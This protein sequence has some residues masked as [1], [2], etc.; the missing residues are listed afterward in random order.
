MAASP[1]KSNSTEIFCP[2]TCRTTSARPLSILCN[3]YGFWLLC[4]NTQTHARTHECTKH[5]YVLHIPQYTTFKDNHYV[6]AEVRIWSLL[7][8]KEGERDF[9]FFRCYWQR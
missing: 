2:R 7:R 9:P 4:T 3:G 5:S 1:L 6:Y 8:E